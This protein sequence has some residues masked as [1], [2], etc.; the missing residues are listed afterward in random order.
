MGFAVKDGPY[1]TAFAALRPPPPPPPA[2]TVDDAVEITDDAIPALH[3][4]LES[5]SSPHPAHTCR[6]V[7]QGVPLIHG[8]AAVLERCQRPLQTSAITR[9]F[10]LG[11]WR[12]YGA[13]EATEDAVLVVQKG[14][15]DSRQV[16]VVVSVPRVPAPPAGGGGGGGG[17]GGA[18]DGI[19]ELD[20]REDG[21]ERLLEERDRVVSPL[22]RSA[23]F[24]DRDMISVPHPRPLGRRV[25]DHGLDIRSRPPAPLEHIALALERSGIVARHGGLPRQ[26]LLQRLPEI[27]LL[28]P[29]FRQ[30][31]HL[32]RK[33]V[34]S[35]VRFLPERDDSRRVHQFRRSVGAVVEYLGSRASEFGRDHGI[36]D[37]IGG[38]GGW[39]RRRGRPSRRMLRTIRD[40]TE[41]TGDVHVAHRGMRQQRT[42]RVVARVQNLREVPPPDQRFEHD[43]VRTDQPRAQRVMLREDPP[44]TTQCV[45]ENVDQL[46]EILI[47]GA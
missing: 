16:V 6:E 22:P 13:R 19:V 38:G 34:A 23:A 2:I 32:R 28:D 17:G 10:A 41:R 37:R 47:D 45:V 8:H 20:D 3:A 18:D 29:A 35:A 4:R 25:G 21:P 36:D 40:V 7:P 43:A 26:F 1:T 31:D 30:H 14:Y 5:V 9:D 11:R 44:P 33:A 15:D 42:R 46:E 12:V 39:R 27:V 24:H